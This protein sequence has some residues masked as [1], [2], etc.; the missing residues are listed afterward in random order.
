MTQNQIDWTQFSSILIQRERGVVETEEW[1][2][3]SHRNDDDHQDSD[4]SD[5][6]TSTNTRA[7]RALKQKQSKQSDTA[8]N[9]KWSKTKIVFTMNEQ[10][11]TEEP[12]AFDEPTK[13]KTRAQ[14]RAVEEIPEP[15]APVQK[16]TRREQRSDYWVTRDDKRR[17]S[18]RSMK[19]MMSTE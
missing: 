16:E 11:P 12:A 4:N 17:S 5:A 15:A 10:Q 14:R 8:K 1:N 19:A 18:A 7:S 2:H 13:A 6:S 3:G 9:V